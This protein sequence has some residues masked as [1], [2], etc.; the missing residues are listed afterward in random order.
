MRTTKR[1][2][3]HLALGAAALTLNACGGGGGNDDAVARTADGVLIGTTTRAAGTTAW[4]GIP[5]AQPPV[6]ELRWRAPKDPQPWSGVRQ[7]QQFGAGCLQGGSTRGPGTNNTFD[8]TVAT[9]LNQPVGSEDCLTLN[10]WRPTNDQKNLPV[11]VF[12][13]GGSNIAG[14]AADPLYDGAELARRANAVVVTANYRVGVMGWLSLDTLRTGNVLD[15]SGNFGTLD[16]IAAL[17]YV[18]RNI[19]AFGG[20]QGN[21]TVMGQSAGAFNVYAL[22]VSPLA[23]GLFHKAIPLSGSLSSTVSAAVPSVTIASVAVQKLYANTLLYA[24]VIDD[25]LAADTAAAKAWVDGQ[26]D[27][28]VSTYLR[29]KSGASII[30]TAL[31]PRVTGLAA[32][33]TSKAVAVNGVLGATASAPIPEGTVIPTNPIA[34]ILAGQYN[35]VPVL[36]GNTR[37]EAKLFGSFPFFGTPPSPAFALSNAD[38]FMAMKNFDPDAAIP[39]PTLADVIKAEYLPVD[40]VPG[41]WNASAAFFTGLFFNGLGDPKTT[42][43]TAE[44]LNA[45]KTQQNDV[46]YYR[47]DWDKQPA[48]WNDVYGAGHAFDVPFVFGNFERASLISRV[49]AGKANEAGRLALSEAMLRSVASFAKTG[50]PNNPTLGVQW[51]PWPQQINFNASLTAAQITAP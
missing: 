25:G 6:G 8:D 5:F 14:Y 42:G 35:R 32:T 26:T 43:P 23:A 29:N 1:Y 34:S 30:A 46:Y 50:N 37:D 9:T 36:A 33:A 11:I 15:D 2:L 12:F 20:D 13:Y 38:R 21:V 16:T 31:K 45:L 48:P 39:N 22:M 41:G 7:A 40:K 3:S 10:I 51:E 27:T 44:M 49:I 47:F 19:G 28:Q 18:S 17:K 24:I 4:L